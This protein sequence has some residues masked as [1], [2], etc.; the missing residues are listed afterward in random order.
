MLQARF[1]GSMIGAACMLLM[2]FGV[3]ATTLADERAGAEKD[4]KAVLER[5][6]KVSPSARKAIE[7]SAGYA[8][9][10][11]FGLKL[12]VAGGGRG[13]G[14]AVG[15]DGSKTYMRFV[16]V[17]AGVGVG[18]KSYDLIFVFGN[19]QAL[20]D[21]INQG[22]EYG[23]QGTVAAKLEGKGTSFEGAVSV[24][25]GVWLYQVTS[26]G[27]SAELTLKGSKYYKD[28]ELN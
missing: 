14:L 2:A 5:L 22:W 20:A 11:N 8:T 15:R 17:Q 12:G 7:Q 25:P 28:K 27:L 4:S 13:K 3:A 26:S 23:G 6:Y 9:F 24:S 19:E 18:I 21:F 10:H 16:E 1:R